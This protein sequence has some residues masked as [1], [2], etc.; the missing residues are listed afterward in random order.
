[1]VRMRVCVGDRRGVSLNP[2]S[3]RKKYSS[4]P[5]ASSDPS[6]VRARPWARVTSCGL[7]EAICVVIL[8]SHKQMSHRSAR[9]ILNHQ[10]RMMAP[11]TMAASHGEA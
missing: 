3:T 9:F 10:L 4:R 5:L 8:T 6:A 2:F 1:M 7:A 11:R